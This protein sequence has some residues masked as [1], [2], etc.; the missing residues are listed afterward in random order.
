MTW[1][2]GHLWPTN[3]SNRS[4]MP[5]GDQPPRPKSAGPR[6]HTLPS[7]PTTETRLR[8]QSSHKLRLPSV[9]W[10]WCLR[11]ERHGLDKWGTLWERVGKNGVPFV[12]SFV[13]F[14]WLLLFS[15]AFCAFPS[16]S[17]LPSSLRSSPFCCGL[18]DRGS[19]AHHQQL[20]NEPQIARYGGSSRREQI[21]HALCVALNVH[22]EREVAELLVCSFEEF[23]GC[24]CWYIWY[25]RSVVWRGV[26]GDRFFVLHSRVWESHSEFSSWVHEWLVE[27]LLLVDL[28]VANRGRRSV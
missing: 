27:R 11:R 5:I 26:W 28:R 13:D 9:V 2:N 4:P 10:R 20:L 22:L 6:T 18:S 24:F 15:T 7:L 21:M 12:A 17:A 8:L 3:R 1:N 19:R 23:F 16:P 14:C 25:R